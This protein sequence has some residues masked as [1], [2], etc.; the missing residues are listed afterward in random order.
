VRVQK[1]FISTPRRVNG[2]SEVVG[3][4]VSIAQ[5]LKEKYKAKL[6]IPGGRG[7]QTK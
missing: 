6:K 7:L 1:I 2:N 4:G 5:F 3:G